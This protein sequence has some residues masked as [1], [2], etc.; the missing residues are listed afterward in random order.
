MSFTSPASAGRFFTSSVNP[1][2]PI[3][4]LK[5]LINS[6]SMSPAQNE[7]HSLLSFILSHPF[8]PFPCYSPNIIPNRCLN[9]NISERNF[10]FF[11]RT[12]PSSSVS[13]HH[14]PQNG[15]SQTCGVILNSSL[16]STHLY[17][18]IKPQFTAPPAHFLSLFTLYHWPGHF[19]G[20]IRDT[21]PN[22]LNSHYCSAPGMGLLPGWHPSN[23]FSML[24]LS[25]KKILSL[26][27]LTF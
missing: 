1:G 17:L 23:L 6:K 10:I 3:C 9:I 15:S 20:L 11:P 19:P 2:S 4:H 18:N 5:M 8:S 25:K 16:C 26:L 7:H 13:R 24:S 22:F 21:S 14:H 12:C 27:T